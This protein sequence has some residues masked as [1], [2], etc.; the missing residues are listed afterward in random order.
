[1]PKQVTIT[2]ARDQ[3]S[4][5]IRTAEH[6]T[7]VVVTRRGHAVAVIIAAEEFDQLDRLRA[8]GPRA[9]LVGLAGGWEGSEEL[10]RVLD[11]RQRT[12]PRRTSA[13]D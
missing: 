2:E 13:V 8:V 6:G 9:G 5:H 11:A 3:L 4:A 7:P 12:P 1:M 10:V